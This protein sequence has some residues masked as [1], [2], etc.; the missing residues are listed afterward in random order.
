[1]KKIFLSLF[2][3]SSTILFAQHNDKDKNVPQTVRRSFEKENPSVKSEGVEWHQKNGEWHANYKDNSQRDV[4]A[5]YDRYGNRKDR[6]I[7]WDR[8]DVPKDLDTKINTRY[9]VNG[10]Y[11]VY[12][13]ERPKMQPLFQVR[14]GT[15]KIV[16][17]DEKGR[18]QK[19]YDRH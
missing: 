17:L 11:K 16:Y 1:M 19:Y 10:N 2:L 12:R 18:E 14:I 6:H 3:A 15:S 7:A 8:N 13:I 5:Y 9:H 4:D